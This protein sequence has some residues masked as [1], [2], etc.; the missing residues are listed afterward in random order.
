MGVTVHSGRC[1]PCTS[2][3]R[4]GERTAVAWGLALASGS[5]VG[6]PGLAADTHGHQEH[7]GL[8]MVSQVG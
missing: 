3:R 1:D 5:Q 8:K 2:E 6:P 7:G 4:E